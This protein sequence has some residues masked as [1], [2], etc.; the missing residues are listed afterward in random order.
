MLSHCSRDAPAPQI[1]GNKCKF[2]ARLK[3]REEDLLLG[4][5]IYDA[6]RETLNLINHNTA[7]RTKVLLMGYT[8]KVDHHD[9]IGQFGKTTPTLPSFS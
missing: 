6:S 9:I 7:L 4:S 8:S 2:E 3:H 5:L 1:E